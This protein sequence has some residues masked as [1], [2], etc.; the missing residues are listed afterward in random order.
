MPSDA[1]P[2]VDVGDIIRLVGQASFQR[3][4]GYARGGAVAEFVWD[5]ASQ[6]LNSAVQGNVTHPYRCHITL[7]SAK[8]GFYRPVSSSCTCP[9]SENCKHVA[10][11][12]LVSNDAHLKQ[13]E[14]DN[15]QTGSQLLTRTIQTKAR[16]TTLTT[17]QAEPSWKTTMTALTAAKAPSTARP[18]GSG[19]PAA[20]QSPRTP[21]GLQFELREQTPRTADRWRGPTA[22]PASTVAEPGASYRLGVRPVIPGSTGNWVRTNVTWNSITHQMNQLALNPEQHRWFTEFAALYRATTRDVY[23]GADPDWIYLDDFH[24][25]LLWPLLADAKKLGIELVGTKK[26]AVVSIAK[27]AVV[28][29]DASRRGEASSSASTPSELKDLY[30]SAVLMI[31]GE[32]YPV[33]QAGALGYHGVYHYELAP[34]PVYVLAPSN[35]PLSDEQRRLLKQP[36][37]MVV[38][39]DDV[40]EFINEFYPKLRRSVEVTSTDESVDFPEIVPPVLVLTATFRAKHVLRLA[41]DWEY[42]D[43]G[44]LSR[45]PLRATAGDDELRD[46]IAEKTV[47]DLAEQV[48]NT[49]SES[50]LDIF[51]QLQPLTTLQGLPAAEFTDKTLPVIEKLPGI[52]VEI[53]GTK[54]DYQELTEAPTLTIKTVETN[55]RDWFDLGVIISIEGRDIPFGPLFKAL[56]KGQKKLLLVDN[57]YLSLDHPAF[58]ELH[59]LIDEASTL[60]EWDTAP[61]ISRYQA[62]LWADFEDLADETEQAQSWRTA[63][64][65]MVELANNDLSSVETTLLPTSIQAT[66]RPYQQEGFN[67]LAF[68]WKHQLGGVLADDMGL[69]KTLQTL[70]LISH[71][72]EQRAAQQAAG[73]QGDISPLKPFLV[74]APT[75]VVSNWLAEAERFAPGLTVRALTATEGKSGTR[76]RSTATGAD[77]VITSYALFRLDFEAYQL[78]DWAGL[79]LDEAQFVKNRT[80]KAHEAAVEL[81]APFK[82]AIT[83]TPMENSLTDLWSLFAIVA[84]GLFPSARKFAEEYVRPIARGENEEQMA[85]LR[86]RIRPLMMRRSKEIVAK[87]LPAKQ[88]QELRIDLSPRH[89]NIYDTYLQRERQKLLGLIGDMDKNR[90][91]VFRS[92]T[93]LRMLSL[94]ASLVDEQY[95]DIPSSKLDVLLEQLEDVVAEG[96]RALIFSQFTSF[97]GKAETRLKEAGIDYA[98]LDGSTLR[99]SEV[100]DRFKK[101]TAPVFLI[102]LKAGGFGLNLTE[103]DY[104]FM[105]DPWWN[106]ASE[107]QAID[108]THRIGQTKNVMVY[109][110]VAKGTIEEKVMALKAQKAKL[111]SQVMDDDAKFSAT[112]TADDIRG[113]LD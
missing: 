71:A 70:S 43:A 91:I 34:E 35:E 65:G 27:R 55:Q 73:E 112:L 77:I 15:L 26:N 10:A 90:F 39:G 62:A 61:R 4:R 107:A 47:V 64:A 20:S 3:A 106:P 111:F 57:S 72:I 113:L 23:T 48:L 58:A 54:P 84:P 102:S 36:E 38:P 69:G 96:H 21:L 80:S 14:R 1:P 25:P 103:A 40:E 76:V 24:S 6:A 100:I 18:F 94:D 63:V 75:S 19:P 98:Y 95:S 60:Q 5:P 104:V 82:L 79:I 22:R 85:K 9:V 101:G 8:D 42:S 44:K 49:A 59:R 52:R 12:M 53:A 17:S 99:R 93:L 37:P 86:R 16:Q 105:L 97:L 32:Q 2:L 51:E 56:S 68:L 89:K 29:L 78:Q 31:D 87:D 33:G 74:V 66:L 7:T 110:L 50:S 81:N 92:L 46:A 108:R 13:I 88:E 83:G 109:R 41:W 30:L 45:L 28:S 67:W 11:T